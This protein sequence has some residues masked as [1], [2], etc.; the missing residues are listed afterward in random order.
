MREGTAPFP[1][2]VRP[3]HLPRMARVRV[4]FP[5]PRVSDVP[6]EVTAQMAALPLPDLRGK[7]VAVTA[8]SRGITG[9]A[10]I[11]SG[12]VADLRRRGADPVLVAAMGSHGGVTAEGQWKLL[13]HLGVTE[14]A[15]G[16]RMLTD[17]DVVELGQTGGG[18]LAYCDRNAAACDGI[19]VVNRVKPHT[20][21]AEPFGS[22]LL[23]MIAVG[24]S[25][26]PCRLRIW[27]C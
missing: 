8:G 11:L 23:K 27:T 13:E 16:A 14:A 15:V 3:E 17:M 9:I 24:P 6:A 25:C 1:L 4:T 2:P 7:R 18:L 10:Q 21:F 19:L 12:I 5:R 26:P 22:G 20:A